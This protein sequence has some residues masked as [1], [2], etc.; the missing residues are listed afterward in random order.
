MLTPSPAD[1]PPVLAMLTA[2]EDSASTSEDGPTSRGQPLRTFYASLASRA[3]A[4]G[5]LRVGVMHIGQ[6]VTGVQLVSRYTSVCG[7]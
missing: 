6:R 5:T 3:A 7:C 4:R 2:M 1:V